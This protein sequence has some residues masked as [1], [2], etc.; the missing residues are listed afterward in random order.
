MELE[1]T[2]DELEIEEYKWQE[3]GE[4]CDACGEEVDYRSNGSHLLSG[5]SEPVPDAVI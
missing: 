1:F 2:S 3:Y 4:N 5:R